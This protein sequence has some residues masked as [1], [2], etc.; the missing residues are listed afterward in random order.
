MQIILLHQKQGKL[1]VQARAGISIIIIEDHHHQQV[2]G[3]DHRQVETVQ[4]VV[5]QAVVR[6]EQSV[7]SPKIVMVACP[8]VATLLAAAIIRN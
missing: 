5:Y 4:A 6:R 1:V 7:L 8:T 2:V 3:S